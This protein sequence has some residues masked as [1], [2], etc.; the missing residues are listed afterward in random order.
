MMR[1]TGTCSRIGPLMASAT[2]LEIPSPCREFLDDVDKQLTEVIEVRCLGGFVVTL[3]HGLPRPT[4]DLDYIE[5][6]PSSAARLLQQIAGPESEL[7]RKYGLY[8]QNAAVANLPES[9]V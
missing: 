9:Y 1:A 4:N 3:L 8:F 5:T 2:P 6:V 7:A